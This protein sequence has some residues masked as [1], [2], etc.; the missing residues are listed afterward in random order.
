MNKPMLIMICLTLL[1][2]SP[3]SGGEYRLSNGWPTGIHA[4][5]YSMP[6]EQKADCKRIEQALNLKSFDKPALCHIARNS[7]NE[8]IRKIDWT[9]LDEDRVLKFA[10]LDEQLSRKSQGHEFNWTAEREK[11]YKDKMAKGQL[12]AS[13]ANIPFFENSTDVKIVKISF[14]IC[15]DDT[16]SYHERY[17]YSFDGDHFNLVSKTFNSNEVFLF[18]NQTYIVSHTT[19]SRDDSFEYKLTPPQK[20]IFINK[21]TLYGGHSRKHCRFIFWD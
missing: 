1:H 17:L 2:H 10:K 21:P 4:H 8:Q 6:E 11:F 15:H 18:N 3:A 14:G 9:P 19:R 5:I 20:I 7:T 16:E 12:S 13:V